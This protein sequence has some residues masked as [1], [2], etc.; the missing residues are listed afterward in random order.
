ML[1]PEQL[2]RDE[3]GAVAVLGGETA[4]MEMGVGGEDG[5]YDFGGEGGGS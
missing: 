1:G 4:E 5:V 2:E 3:A